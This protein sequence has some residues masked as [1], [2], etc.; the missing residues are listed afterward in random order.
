MTV[1]VFLVCA[2]KVLSFK[3][4]SSILLH[5]FLIILSVPIT[6]L[7]TDICVASGFQVLHTKPPWT[8]LSLNIGSCYKILNGVHRNIWQTNDMTSAM[9]FEVSRLKV[10]QVQWHYWGKWMAH[11]NGTF[12][13]N[14][15]HCFYFSSAYVEVRWQPSGIRSFSS[16][17]DPG[18]NLRLSGLCGKSFFLPDHLIN[19]KTIQ[20]WEGKK[21]NSLK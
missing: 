4:P 3:I 16:L 10:Q 7:L 14:P 17:W 5:D 18:T 12:E 15:W 2:S 9:H 20:K 1:G 11:L 13:N 8:F 19:P 6:L 21:S